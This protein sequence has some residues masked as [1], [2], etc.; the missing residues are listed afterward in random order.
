VK[1]W[2]DMR[3]RLI[4]I[5]N[6]RGL[7]LAKPLLEQVGLSDEVDVEA[8]PGVL[9][10]RPVASPRTGWAEA[11]A[12]SPADGLLDEPINSRFDEEEWQW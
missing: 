6:S 7:R 5:G 3:T 9:T 1:D 10:I 4:K 2:A 11:A 12:A 8:A